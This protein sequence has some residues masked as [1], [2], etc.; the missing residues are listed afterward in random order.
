MV[1]EQG[2]STIEVVPEPTTAALLGI[3]L[4]GIGLARRQ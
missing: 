4:L 1:T 2:F 3:A